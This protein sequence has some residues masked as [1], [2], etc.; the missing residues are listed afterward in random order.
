[1]K[2]CPFCAEEILDEAIKC[3]HCGTSLQQ[4]VKVCPKRNRIY[5]LS[6]AYCKDHFL[7][8]MLQEKNVDTKDIPENVKKELTDNTVSY[9]K[10]EKV[11]QKSNKQGGGCLMIIIGLFLCLLSPWLGGIVAIVGIVLLLISFTE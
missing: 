11:R 7:S 10:K 6:T 4:L 2:K 1:M 9:L 5:A 8:V 3:K